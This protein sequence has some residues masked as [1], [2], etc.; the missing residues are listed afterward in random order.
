MEIFD[1]QS[2]PQRPQYDLTKA[3]RITLTLEGQSVKFFSPEW[4]FR[5]KILSQHGR[6]GSHKGL[7]DVGDVIEMLRLARPGVPE[8]NFNGQEETIEALK[9]FLRKRPQARSLIAEKV[10]CD[11]VLNQL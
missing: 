7:Q 3:T 8:M 10:K 11:A 1:R 2:W 9:S 4:I 5:E 6:E